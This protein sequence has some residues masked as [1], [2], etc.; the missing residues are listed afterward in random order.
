MR[1]MVVAS[2]Y[3]SENHSTRGSFIREQA[4]A[5][6]ELGVEVH[7]VSI[8]RSRPRL[9][10]TVLTS[11]DGPLVEH[12]I[13][14]IWPL[15]R[16]LGFY[17]PWPLIWKL[18]NIADSV[19]PD[20]V[21]AHAV[22][23]AGYIASRLQ[24]FPLVITEHSGPL[25]EFWSTAHGFRQIESAYLKADRRIAV[26]T[27]LMQEIEDLFPGTRGLWEVV[28]NGI[29]TSLFACPS[30]PQ[31]AGDVLYVGSLDENKDVPTLLDAMASL[32][33]STSLTIAGTGPA[34]GTI[35]RRTE[36]LGI[37]DRVSLLGPVSRQQVAELMQSH[38]VF[39]LPSRRE[40]FGIV[41]AEALSCG[42][43]VV[44]TRCGGPEY[45]V[46]EFGG[47]LVPVGDAEAF[48][49]ALRQVLMNPGKFS[50][51]R[52]HDYVAENFSMT[53]VATRLQQVYHDVAGNA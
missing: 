14:A 26:S 44:A 46:P 15:H 13:A 1:V 30:Q 35:R 47:K 18:R 50:P 2:W 49:G 21:H 20:V 10:L 17:L 52:L 7:V 29:D 36:S 34:E 53:S 9:P 28:P 41:C 45:V 33:D 39:A 37:A 16:L 27:A 25:R 19:Q 12:S 43:P 38:T 22:R 48:A 4:L 23:P 3:R 5:I 11:R 42:T 32:A 31:R 8:D 51:R 40:T 24:G 6:A